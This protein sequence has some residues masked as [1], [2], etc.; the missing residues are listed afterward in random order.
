M[1][2]KSRMVA[3]EAA[4]QKA[5]NLPPESVTAPVDLEDL[6][7]VYNEVELQQKERLTQLLYACIQ[8]G[9]PRRVEFGA[10]AW[11]NMYPTD[12]FDIATGNYVDRFIRYI[13]K[14]G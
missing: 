2:E 11:T 1:S 4:R 3:A 10:D 5:L 13:T 12:R 7:R 9:G 6:V 8:P 14:V